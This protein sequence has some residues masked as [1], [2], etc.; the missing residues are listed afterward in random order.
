MELLCIQTHSKSVVIAGNTYPLIND[1]K[2][3]GC[4]GVVDVGVKVSNEVNIYENGVL[5]GEG[6]VGI[7]DE[8]YCTYCDKPYDF[9]GVWWISKDLFA[10]IATSEEMTLHE[11]EK[12][13]VTAL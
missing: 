6:K 3:C 13:H 11:T 9:D 5:I 10:P 4:K 2:P 8:I 12:Q 1:K 7:G